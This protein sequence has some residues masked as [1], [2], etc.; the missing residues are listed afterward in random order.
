MQGKVAVILG[1]SG[2]IGRTTSALFARE[3]ARVVVGYGHGRET[4]EQLV[5]SLP[6]E[7]HFAAEVHMEDTASINRLAETVAARAGRAD[8]LVN[9]AGFSRAIPHDDLDA[10]EDEF[11]DRM[12]AVNWRGQFAA[13]RAFRKLLDQS[14]DGLVVN[15]SSIS[16]VSGS[17][18]NLAYCAVKAAT[19]SMTRSLA[20]ALAPRIRVMSVSPSA[21]DTQFVPGRDAAYNAKAAALTPLKRI[22]TPDDVGRAILACATMLTY[23]T[24]SIIL[25]DGGR[26][27]A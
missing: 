13:I 4:A 17:G 21:V 14:D 3:G 9:G 10:L 23:S 11:I 16:G 25:V 22:A 5:A 1:G 27:V 7:G 12:F 8:V 15:I 24:G 19:D 18:S 2:G 26:F 6:G 20:R